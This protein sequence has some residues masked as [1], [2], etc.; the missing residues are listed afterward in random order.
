LDRGALWKEM[1]KDK[2]RTG[3]GIA[4]V[5]PHRSLALHLV[6]DIS[7]DEFNHGVSLLEHLK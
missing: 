1:K 4:M 5:L 2:K 3:N 7:W 6:Q